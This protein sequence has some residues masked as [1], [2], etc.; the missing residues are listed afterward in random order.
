MLFLPLFSPCVYTGSYKVCEVVF[1]S[2]IIVGLAPARV[3]LTA[4]AKYS[5]LKYKILDIC[6]KLSILSSNHIICD[7]S[8]LCPSAAHTKSSSVAP[9]GVM[10]LRCSSSVWDHLCCRTHWAYRV[11]WAHRQRSHGTH[12]RS[13]SYLSN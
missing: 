13:Q 10:R 11:N 3:T 2:H 8:S 1:K 6:G 9:Y 4:V 7:V 5:D 12:S